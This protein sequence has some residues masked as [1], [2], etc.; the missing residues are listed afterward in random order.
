MEPGEARNAQINAKADKGSRVR[1]GRWTD[2]RKE[3]LIE[4][5]AMP[6]SGSDTMRTDGAR[7]NGGIGQGLGLQCRDLKRCP[8]A[9]PG[10]R[11]RAGY[12]RPQRRGSYGRLPLGEAP[13]TPPN[14]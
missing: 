13:Q 1:V 8:M 9:A 14:V 12:G 2:F 4:L 3:R 11:K 5:R 10:V 7:V 6:P